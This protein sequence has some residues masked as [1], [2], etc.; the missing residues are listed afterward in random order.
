MKQPACPPQDLS[1]FS[2]PFETHIQEHAHELA[3]RIRNATF[4]WEFRP[5]FASLPPPA[6]ALTAELFTGDLLA[7]L[8][9][10]KLEE[11]IRRERGVAH[12][13]YHGTYGGAGEY[14]SLPDLFGGPEGLPPAAFRYLAAMIS[15]RE[16]GFYAPDGSHADY[17]VPMADMCNTDPG[18]TNVVQHS[19]F[20]GCGDVGG[21][22]IFTVHTIFHSHP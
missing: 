19:E 11:L 8:H 6:A 18:R 17:L 9:S 14:A 10:P 13:V 15:S 2:I 22:Y 5:Y 4:F 16:F 20:L 7:M 21:W 3:I 1:L 12:A